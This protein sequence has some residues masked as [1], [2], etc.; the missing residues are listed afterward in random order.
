M[1]KLHLSLQRHS[2]Q[3]CLSFYKGDFVKDISK[4]KTFSQADPL[5]LITTTALEAVEERDRSAG[6]ALPT[7]VLGL[8]QP[9]EGWDLVAETTAAE[10]ERELLAAPLTSQK[11]ISC[12]A[13]WEQR[14]R[15]L[16]QAGWGDPRIGTKPARPGPGRQSFG[17]VCARSSGNTTKH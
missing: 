13:R 16:A 5:F 4:K 10:K 2:D 6:E 7:A 11:Q 1:P 12:S 15:C 3:P 14:C 8:S 9:T 17:S